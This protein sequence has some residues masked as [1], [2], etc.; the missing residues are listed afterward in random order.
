MLVLVLIGL[1]QYLY[2]IACLVMLH[3]GQQPL[4]V[5]VQLWPFLGGLSVAGGVAG[6][7]LFF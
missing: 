2:F 5:H 4:D 7:T 1:F 3:D 6:A